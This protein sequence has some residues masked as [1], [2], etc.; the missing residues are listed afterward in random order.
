MN[1]DNPFQDLCHLCFHD[2][3]AHEFHTRGKNPYH[4]YFTC[5]EKDCKCCGTWSLNEPMPEGLPV[6]NH[7]RVRGE[8]KTLED[9]EK[10]FERDFKIWLEKT[11]NPS[12]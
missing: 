6:Q 4:G 8:G 3:N 9:L 12:N 2:S 7:L 5:P 11:Q 10:M 1:S